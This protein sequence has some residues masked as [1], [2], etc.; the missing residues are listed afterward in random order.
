MGLQLWLVEVECNLN[1][2][3]GKVQSKVRHLF[4]GE[5]SLVG[6]VLTLCPTMT[7]TK[8]KVISG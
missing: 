6:A 5:L 8:A 3:Q 4:M 1:F 2:S 7:P